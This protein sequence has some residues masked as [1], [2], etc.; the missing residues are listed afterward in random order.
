MNNPPNFQLAPATSPSL[1]RLVSDS[2]FFAVS[3]TRSPQPFQNPMST[4]SGLPSGY[5]GNQ[6]LNYPKPGITQSSF[7]TNP[8][9][10]SSLSM[11]QTSLYT[12]PM[13]TTSLTAPST[14][15][16]Q[17]SMA[18][19]TSSQPPQPRTNFEDSG[20]WRHKKVETLSEGYKKAIY[21][22]QQDIDG[23]DISLRN[24]ESTLEKLSEQQIRVKDKTNQLFS[25]SKKVIS[26]QRR[27]QNA[28]DILK[29]FENNI[30]KYVR[31]FIKITEQCNQADAFHKIQAPAAFLSDILNSCETQIKEME[32][33]INDMEEIIKLETSRPQF[34]LLVQTISLMMDKF[35]IVGSISADLHNRVLEF[36]Y[37]ASEMVKDNF[38]QELPLNL[39]EIKD[40][41]EL[42]AFKAEESIFSGIQQSESKRGSFTANKEN[43]FNRYQPVKQPYSILKETIVGKTGILQSPTP[44]KL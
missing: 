10:L 22:I 28:L 21:E 9:Q 26:R 33:N 17:W 36:Q 40:E 19:P 14:M 2:N 20:Y 23:N 30:A 13:P 29:T 7:F 42:L 25:Y 11:P 38:H 35:K 1:S 43:D 37:K 4:P 24:S 44:R 5:G 39:N 34:S 12:N 41:T 6:Y 27:C 32:R 15:Y 18:P 8:P 31:E 3:G 16:P